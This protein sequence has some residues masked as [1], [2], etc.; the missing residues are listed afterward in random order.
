MKRINNLIA[1]T[2]EAPDGSTNL[3]ADYRK[4]KE[5][6]LIEENLLYDMVHYLQTI[7]F[8]STKNL[9]SPLS[10]KKRSHDGSYQTKKKDQ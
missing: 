1:T 4:E 7:G 5:I 9:P 8:I 2:T 3:I 10:R 6:L